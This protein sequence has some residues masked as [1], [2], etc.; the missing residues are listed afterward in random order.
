MTRVGCNRIVCHFHFPTNMSRPILSL[1]P[2]LTIISLS[3]TEEKIR[4]YRVAADDASSE[5]VATA[6]VPNAPAAAGPLRWQVPEGWKEEAVGQFQTAL[7]SLGGDAKVSVSKLP[8]DAGG[9]AANVNR[10]QQQVGLEPSD[11]VFME[12][13]A[14]EDDGISVKWC[15]LEGKTDSIMAAIISLPDETWFF[16]LTAPTLSIETKAKEF[17]SLL[18]S[19]EFAAKAAE[20]PAAPAPAAAE[21]PGIGLDVPEGWVK[22]EGSAM[23]V[24]SFSIP[25]DGTP[26]GDVSVIPLAGQSGT[27]LENVNRWRAQL[28]LAA[29]ASEDDPALGKKATGVSGEML[30]T[31]MVSEKNVFDDDSK[32]GISTA[33]LRAGE[34]TWFFK[35]GGEAEL[36]SRNRE[37]FEAFV[38]SAKLP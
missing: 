21:K 14:V 29:L 35:L 6:A 9:E 1:L 37:K 8:G 26:D 23:R 12:T 38:L 13:V 18:T 30:I 22:S 10:W 19:V 16:K 32:G 4:T 27:T 33:I 7:Y 34:T 28:Q 5:P 15:Q 25:G 17:S 36:V 20:P 2:F 24:A 11:E 3:C 31:H